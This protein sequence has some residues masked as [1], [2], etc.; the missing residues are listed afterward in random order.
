MLFSLRHEELLFSRKLRS[1]FHLDESGDK[2]KS[3]S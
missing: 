2:I 3:K 1:I